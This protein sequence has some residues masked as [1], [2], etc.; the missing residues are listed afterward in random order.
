MD[1]TLLTIQR[2]Y[3]KILQRDP[4][5]AGLDGWVAA[6]DSGL[7]TLDQVRSAII[8]SPEARDFVLPIVRLYQ[9]AFGRVP[10][11]AGLDGWVDALRSGVSLQTIAQGFVD[12]A[13]FAATYGADAGVT[14]AY[15]TSLYANLLERLPEAAETV[16]NWLNSGL[17]R[18]DMMLSFINSAE[19]KAHAGLAAAA[20]LNAAAT[21]DESYTGSLYE[22]DGQA[23]GLTIGTDL[24]TGSSGADTFDAP[25]AQNGVGDLYS[26]LQTSDHVSGGNGH[27]I[28]NWAFDGEAAYVSE[29]ISIVPTLRAIEVV[30]VTGTNGG[31]TLD[32]WRSTG[33]EEVHLLDSYAANLI[34]RHADDATQVSIER[35]VDGLF[36]VYDALAVADAYVTDSENV[37]LSVNGNRDLSSALIV[38]STDSSIDVQSAAGELTSLVAVEISNGDRSSINIAADGVANVYT[39]TTDAVIGGD[40]WTVL[41]ED[42]QVGSID[43]VT[44]SYANNGRAG[45]ASIGG[46]ANLVV[47]DSPDF[48][49]DIYAHAEAEGTADAGDVSV[50]G[51]ATITITGSDMPSLSDGPYFYVGCYTE[52]QTGNVGTATTSGLG[53]VLIDSSDKVD[54]EIEAE[55]YAGTGDAG[56]AAILGLTSVE[57]VSS[58]DVVVT[59]D[60]YSYADTGTVG[61][62]LVQGPASIVIAESANAEVDIYAES[63]TD[64]G[65]APGTATISGLA[66]AQ[67][68]GSSGA[69]LDV[70]SDV[71]GSTSGT[72]GAVLLE[73]PS[74]ISIAGSAGASMSLTAHAT[75]D[76]SGGSSDVQI[77]S[78]DTATIVGSANATLVVGASN[79]A[80]MSG[81]ASVD[82][83]ASLLLNTSAAASVTV[84][85]N[86]SSEY[87]ISGTASV[88]GLGAIAITSSA[89]A[90]VAISADAYTYEGTAGDAVVGGLT[91]ITVSSSAGATVTVDATSE[92]G[93]SSGTIGSAAIEG[94]ATISITDSAAASVSLTAT[95]GGDDLSTDASI[96]GLGSITILDSDGA[97]VTASAYITEGYGL[98]DGLDTIDVTGSDNATVTVL[99]LSTAE[100]TVTVTDSENFSLDLVEGSGTAT[101]TF[102]LNLVAP[103]AATAMTPA[104]LTFLEAPN[105]SFE[106]F[107][108]DTAGDYRIDGAANLHVD[109]LVVTG[110][111]SLALI[112][113]IVGVVS[114]DASGF[115]G[116][117]TADINSAQ[118]ESILGGSGV[119][120]L[121]FDEGTSA[122]EVTVDGQGGND[123]FEI[124][125]IG[126]ASVQRFLY[127]DA[128][129]AQIEAAAPGVLTIS[130]A[131]SIE[132]ILGFTTG[133]DLVD[134]SGFG[135]T[136][137]TAAAFDATSI[138]LTA[139]TD[140]TSII[141]FFDNSGTDNRVAF[142]TVGSN[143]FVFIDANADGDFTA[144]ADGMFELVG[145]T[146][147]TIGD[148]AFA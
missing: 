57:V 128:T 139:S 122:T 79:T 21:L 32:L 34:V 116:D 23:F 70:E 11:A 22:R 91:S 2:Y 60:A 30:N 65:E 147:F 104:V 59:I 120:D 74:S 15:I 5:Q 18:T 77:T 40:G 114:L 126:L 132:T 54:F 45:S 112:G 58:A 92:E 4:D 66:T 68:V 95:L 144:A 125:A 101:D 97:A 51:P 138:S 87:G 85:A 1:P 26:T 53:T 98:V 90:D 105:P 7:L 148:V 135:F 130:N 24:V 141:D 46:I 37:D 72:L 145:V 134:V 9:A 78:L 8:V 52:S 133:E 39:G 123:A 94:P 140:L 109:A 48:R 111:D 108:I 47:Q 61:S 89:S 25:L 93:D 103:V 88:T 100:L 33:V 102:N 136:G 27:D 35:S 113:G 19:A 82:G 62:S 63:D 84:S 56:D 73:G 12:S 6:V 17:S 127:G 14:I 106:T 42:A 143:T 124:L 43:I 86:T 55:S 36:Q 146:S 67:I 20:F 13:E 107:A 29:G 121:S 3:T 71:N 119:D 80:E 49:I 44:H 76:G 83:L 75:N 115:T 142:A 131:A 31:T 16:E 69:V 137:A 10:D 38:D 81:A 99:G 110:T 50:S 118:L 28:L 64:S 96:T 117:L 129:D 41:I